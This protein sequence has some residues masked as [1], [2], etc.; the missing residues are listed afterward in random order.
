[1]NGVNQSNSCRKTYI[2]KFQHQETMQMPKDRQQPSYSV[3]FTA[4]KEHWSIREN[5]EFDN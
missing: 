1:M 4:R 3:N 2:S 5:Y